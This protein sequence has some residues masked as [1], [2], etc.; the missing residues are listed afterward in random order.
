MI[1]VEIVKE[2]VYLLIQREAI[3]NH[4]FIMSKDGLVYRGKLFE[5]I[6]LFKKLVTCPR[7]GLR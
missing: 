7:A 3:S 5:L 2:V 1:M 4:S 6:T